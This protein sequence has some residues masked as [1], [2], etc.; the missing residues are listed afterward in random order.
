[1]VAAGD[2]ALEAFMAAPHDIAAY[3]AEI[4]KYMR[5]AMQIAA[6]PNH[7]PCPSGLFH[8]DC[9]SLN[10]GLIQKA[11]RF[12]QSLFHAFSQVTIQINM[13]IRQQFKLMVSRLSKKPVDLYELV[14]AEV[15]IIG[16]FFYP[17]LVDGGRRT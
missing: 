2:V 1:M 10:A 17:G 8:V 9:T 15:R 3:A 11:S 6:E 4:G 16:V 12:I 14:D 13:D 5:F 7:G